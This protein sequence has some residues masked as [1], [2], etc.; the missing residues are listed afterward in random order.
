M[1]FGNFSRLN[2]EFFPLLVQLRHTADTL[3]GTESVGS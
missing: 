3:Q 1:Q 2:Q